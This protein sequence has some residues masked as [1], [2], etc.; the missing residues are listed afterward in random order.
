MVPKLESENFDDIELIRPLFLV[1]EKDII[2]WIKKSGIQAMNCGCTVVAEKTSSKRREIKTLLNTLRETNPM[3]D[4]FI[5]TASGNVNL[6]AILG[7][8]KDELKVDYNEIYKNRRK[9]T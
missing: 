1:K 7:Y 6:D 4:H 3:I 9:K 5:F 8:H 2:R